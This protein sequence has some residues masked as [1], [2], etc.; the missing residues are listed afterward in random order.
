MHSDMKLTAKASLQIQKPVE[1]V[2]E[3]IADPAQLTR[4][5]IASSSGRIEAGAVLTWEFG[6]FPGPFDVTVLEARPHEFI[7]FVWDEAT[8]VNI[9]LQRQE[10]HSTVVRITEGEKDLSPENLEWLI[11]NSFGWG[12]F[13]DC[14]KA[15][16]EYGINLRKGAFDYM[17]PR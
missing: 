14:L 3:A 15:Y 9:S 7:A 1:E 11:S 12:N 13:L 5:F 16:L 17:A 4:Y 8:T 10:D 2:Y 6:D